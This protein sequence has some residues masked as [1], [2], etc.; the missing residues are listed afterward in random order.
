MISITS[1]VTAKTDHYNYFHSWS[2]NYVKHIKGVA[3]K[4]RIFGYKFMLSGSAWM[5]RNRFER[6][7]SSG[8][9]INIL[10]IIDYPINKYRWSVGT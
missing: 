7:K 10:H 8:V 1:Y 4:Q 9:K 6:N 3:S 2:S 5:W